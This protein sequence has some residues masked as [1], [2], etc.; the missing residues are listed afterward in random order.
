ML[1]ELKLYPKYVSMSLRSSLSYK[2]DSIIMIISFAITE[3]VSLATI[4]F[5]VGAVPSIGEWTFE[6]LAFLFGFTLIPKSIDHIFTDELW[7]LAYR[8]IRRGELD[9][10]LTR[11]INPLFQFVAKTFKWDGVGELIVGIVVM[12]IFGPQTEIAFT[13]GGVIALIIC[14]VLGVFVF[15]GFKLLLASLAFWVK[16]VGIFLNTIYSLSNYAKYPLRYMGKAF[17][18]IMFY[19]IPFGLF[20]YY[21]IECLILGNNVWFAVL[22]SFIAA[23]IIMT[24]GLL[25]WRLGIKRY[26]SAGN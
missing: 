12:A 1:K 11:P 13:V 17:M 3:V 25:V 7:I 21:P 9:V 23:V 8:A 18:S 6:R 15:T 2:A 16:Y 26:E 20:L 14:A 19:V 5:I 10:Y 4:Y 22:Y 24:L